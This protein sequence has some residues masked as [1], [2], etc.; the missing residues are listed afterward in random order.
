[1]QA[2][3]PTDGH[4]AADHRMDTTAEATPQEPP[5]DHDEKQEDDEHADD[6]A[7]A[8]ADGA[9]AAAP[10]GKKR[11]LDKQ[12]KRAAAKLAKKTKR[13]EFVKNALQQR[14]GE[15]AAS[16]AT[17]ATPASS[18]VHSGTQ[19][20]QGALTASSLVETD[21]FFTSSSALPGVAAQSQ[22]VPWPYWYEF[23][24]YA[25]RRWIGR[26]IIDV[27]KAEYGKS[28]VTT[29]RTADRRCSGRLEL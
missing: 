25:K 23:S 20:R 19:K 7:A 18:A 22:R 8:A 27:L 1:M 17:A 10:D 3:T 12:T 5:A 15:T 24:T 4:A 29:R 21:Y 13:A 26:S 2:A 6:V 28:V 9:P 16:A 14:T 11:K